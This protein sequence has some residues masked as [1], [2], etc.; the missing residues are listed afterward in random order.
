[1]SHAYIYLIRN[2][3]N[4]KIYIGQTTNL[5]KREKKY[6]CGNCKSQPFI[7]NAIKKYGW[8]NFEFSPI[9]RIFDYNEKIDR[10]ELDFLEIF[11]IAL[12]RSTSDYGNYNLTQGGKGGVPTE[13]TRRK[14][15]ESNKGRRHS[16]E[17]IEKMRLSKIGK[18]H[19][20]EHKRK[21]SEAKKGKALSEDTKQKLSR[22]LK[23][24][25]FSEEHKKRISDG[26]R[27]I[28]R[29]Q[30]TKEK[31]SKIKKGKPVSEKMVEANNG[32]KKAVICNETQR[33][34][35]SMNSCAREMKIRRP[36]ITDHINGRRK[37][38]IDG[39]TFS[40]IDIGVKNES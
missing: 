30:E 37:K 33:I 11:Y 25:Q 29:S 12:Y 3:V 31:L 1:M 9:R 2:K 27:G 20:E 14:N 23:G 26:L 15:S 35:E 13:D 21:N 36:S 38:N 17:S 4:N 39:Y 18:K 22:A 32:R 40:L 5:K 6:A 19:S 7:Y 24:R 10:A 16:K 34:F 28:K 8:K